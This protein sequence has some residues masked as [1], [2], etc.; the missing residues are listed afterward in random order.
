MKFINIMIYGA[1][2]IML[3]ITGI[4]FVVAP[5]SRDMDLLIYLEEFYV[6][7]NEGIFFVQFEN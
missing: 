6:V 4:H 2:V 7:E 5:R 1:L 3:N